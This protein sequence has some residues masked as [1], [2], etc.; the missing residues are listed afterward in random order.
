MYFWNLS[1]ICVLACRM[2]AESGEDEGD[3]DERH[4]TVES[5]ADLLHRANEPARVEILNQQ[6]RH[7]DAVLF[8]PV[9]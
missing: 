2:Q 4:Q 5:E 6:A 1:A 9:S 7:Q 3:D 8:E